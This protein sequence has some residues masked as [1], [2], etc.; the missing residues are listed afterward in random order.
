VLLVAI[1]AGGEPPF[2]I[3]DSFRIHPTRSHE[4]VPKVMI[5]VM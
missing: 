3:I 5:S 2:L 1:V 4:T